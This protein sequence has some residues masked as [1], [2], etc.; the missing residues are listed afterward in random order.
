MFH[1]AK[2]APILVPIR[3]LIFKTPD[4]LRSSWP[5]LWLH[6]RKQRSGLHY[7]TY[8]AA[9]SL[10]DVPFRLSSSLL[11]ICR[12]HKKSNEGCHAHVVE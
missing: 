12:L 4:D 9:A 7:D 8:A 11:Y 2:V 10:A 5:R 6:H 3:Q 1:S